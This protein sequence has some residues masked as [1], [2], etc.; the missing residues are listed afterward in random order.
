MALLQ[1]NATL[2]NMLTASVR[3]LWWD[4]VECRVP[5]L[6]KKEDPSLQQ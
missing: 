3:G 5:S 1:G 6:P 2:R 4:E